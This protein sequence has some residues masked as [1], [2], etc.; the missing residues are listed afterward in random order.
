MR[1]IAGRWLRAGCW[2]AVCAAVG[3]V[4]AVRAEPPP[5]IPL[6]AVRRLAATAVSPDGSLATRPDAAGVV[7]VWVRTLGGSD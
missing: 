3:G 6:G 2:A 4:A 1:A 5:L 7:N